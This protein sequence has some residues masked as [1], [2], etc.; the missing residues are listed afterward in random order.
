MR[1]AFWAGADLRDRTARL[2]EFKLFL[3]TYLQYAIDGQQ[4]TVTQDAAPSE[5]RPSA[6]PE[7]VRIRVVHGV[8]E[9]M[10]AFAVRAAVFLSEQACPY[11]EEFDGN[12]FTA[13]HLLGFV[14]AE[15]ASTCRIRYFADFARLERIAVRRE[16]RKQDV[17]VKMIEFAFDFCRRKGYRKVL[18]QAIERLIPYY[19]R[20]GFER[21]NDETFVVAGHEYVELVSTLEP[22][23]DP[24]AIGK[25]PLVIIR[26][27]G[28]W[29]QPS[30]FEPSASVAE[31]TSTAED[32][33]HVE[34]TAELR[35]RMERLG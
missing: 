12:D 35:Q 29:D 32:Q 34:W 13:T 24:L 6:C 15:P 4:K 3:F 18:G 20:Y 17:A 1:G 11:A 10:Q 22:H 28:A 14:G 23:P 7:T 16:F 33:E 8:E 27:E 2:R 25:D 5:A 26:R 31:P 19:Q 30:Q 9:M 21:I